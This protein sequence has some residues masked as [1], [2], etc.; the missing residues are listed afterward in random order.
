MPVHRMA[1]HEVR[2]LRAARH[3]VG[4]AAVVDPHALDADLQR[5]VES[6]ISSMETDP[7]SGFGVFRRTSSVLAW[8]ALL[9]KALALH[10][11]YFPATLG[12]L[13]EGVAADAFDIPLHLGGDRVMSAREALRLAKGAEAAD[14]AVEAYLSFV[15]T[16]IDNWWRFLFR[17][18]DDAR[19]IRN[20]AAIASQ[21]VVDHVAADASAHDRQLVTASLACGAAGPVHQLVDVLEPALGVQVGS[22]HLVDVDVMALASAYSLARRT[23]AAGRVR[24]L[25]QDPLRPPLAGPDLPPGSVD[26]ADALGLVEYLPEKHAVALLRRV[27]E[28]LLRPG[29]IVVF[30]NILLHR[31]QTVF[32]E[33]VVRWPRLLRRPI[34]TVL[35]LLG[36]AGH[37]P[38]RVS[39]R[40]TPD[41]D[42]AVYAART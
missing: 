37:E 41:G 24:L 40:R 2:T 16:P 42:Y 14:R 29:G 17:G 30:G 22:I 38:G 39:V 3:D 27:R 32:L 18:M 11:V 25:H 19:G 23:S 26:V 15:A 20:R 10:P 33:Q 28:E 31:P 21:F 1:L 36:D 6:R 34:G 7:E 13:G 35:D 9:M 8:G 5:E 4:V 12:R